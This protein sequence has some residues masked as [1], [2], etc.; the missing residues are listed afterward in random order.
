MPPDSLSYIPGGPIILRPHD[1][2]WS[3]AF[4]EAAAQLAQRLSGI[5]VALHHVGSTAI[6]GIAAKPV[7]DILA[8]VTDLEA[9][10]QRA[11]A[12]VAIGYEALGEFGIPQ[13]RYFRRNTPAGV[14]IHQVHAFARGHEQIERMLLFRDYLRATPT[15]AQEYEALKYRLAAQCGDDVERY[16][17]SKTGF[18]EAVLGQARAWATDI[19]MQ[20]QAGRMRLDRESR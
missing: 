5:V 6:P 2:T 16:A 9:L 7:I 15:V 8:V 3:A 13:R 20:V 18:V 17:E 1:A 11:D 12:L 4:D 10:D 19:R 14:R